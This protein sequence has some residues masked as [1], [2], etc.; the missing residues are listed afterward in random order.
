MANKVDYML[1]KNSLGNG[2]PKSVYEVR[3]NLDK[4]MKDKF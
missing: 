2:P 4:S 1:S 3:G